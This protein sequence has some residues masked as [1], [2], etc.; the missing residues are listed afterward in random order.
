MAIAPR[1]RTTLYGRIVESFREQVRRGA[2][3]PGDRA[4]SL[5]RIRRQHRVSMA[6]AIQAYRWL[7]ARGHL[8]ARARSGYFVRTPHAEEIPEPQADTRRGP[9][10]VPLSHTVVREVLAAAGDPENVPFGAGCVDPELFPNR[11]LNLIARRILG[12]QPLHSAQYAMPPGLEALRRQVARRSADFGCRLAP[13]DITITSGALEAIQLALRAVVRPGQAIAVESPTFFTVLEAVAAL[14][15]DVVEIPTHPR[16]GMDLDALEHAIRRRGVRACFTMPN[17]HNPLGYV[18]PDEAKKALVALTARHGVAVIEDDLYGDL[19]LEGPRPR[20]AKSFDRNELV[21]L[22][23]S[24]SKVLAPGFRVGWI[25]AGRYRDEVNRLKFLCNIASPSLPQLAVAEFLETGGYDR[26]LK[27]L[28]V[29][30]R[31]Q[32]ERARHSVA[33]YFPDGTGVSRPAAGHMLWVEL[34]PRTDGVAVFQRALEHRISVLPGAI[35][36]PSR[37]YRN[38]LRLN[39]GHVWSEKYERAMLTL[40]RLCLESP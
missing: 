23:S 14:G 12:R 22:C 6:T 19:A 24:Y 3:R 37:R 8:E 5:R 31:D 26:H 16:N 33:R 25:A 38:Y 39:C 27:R 10:A 34:P 1:E 40:G 7:E 9:R 15:I 21:L 13:G 4:H 35:F 36:S 20:T 30:L 2:L 29:S 18:L 28:R 32:V 11:R 17:G